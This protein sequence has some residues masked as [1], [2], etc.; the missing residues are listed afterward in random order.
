[1]V[2]DAQ[3]YWTRTK[4]KAFR[5][6]VL[7]VPGRVKDLSAHQSVTLT[8]ELRDALTE[9][10]LMNH[11]RPRQLSR[12]ARLETLWWMLANQPHVLAKSR[13][14]IP[15]PARTGRICSSLV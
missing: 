5:N 12:A 7:A 15:S 3:L 6:R 4:L 14:P 8:Q 11:H 9:L 10:A 2:G 13:Y 1:M